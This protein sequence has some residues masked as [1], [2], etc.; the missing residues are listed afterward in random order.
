MGS[1]GSNTTGGIDAVGGWMGSGGDFGTGGI[2]ASGGQPGDG[3]TAGAWSCSGSSVSNPGFEQING[4]LPVDWAILVLSSTGNN[5]LVFVSSTSPVYEGVYSALVDAT[6]ANKAPDGGFVVGST[7][8]LPVTPGGMLEL[9]AAASVATASEPFVISVAYFDAAGGLLG[10]GGT[11]A[12]SFEPSSGFV[13]KGPL[14]FTVP[15]GVAF[16]GV[17]LIAGVGVSA[18]VDAV[19]LRPL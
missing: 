2:P 3:G 14:S 5:K 6:E 18:Y 19:C 4:D 1:G 10:T 8:N 13:V 11:E 16:A 9:T 7:R 17:A 15:D 12:L